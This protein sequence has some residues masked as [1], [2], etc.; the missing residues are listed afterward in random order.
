MS[1]SVL[2]LFRFVQAVQTSATFDLISPTLCWLVIIIILRKYGIYEIS[3][4]IELHSGPTTI[5][6]SVVK[7]VNGQAVVG[8]GKVAA[9]TGRCLTDTFSVSNQNTLPVICGTNTGE[10]GKSRIQIQITQF[11]PYCYIPLFSLLWCQLGVQLAWFQ[12]GNCCC[13]CHCFSNKNVDY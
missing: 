2:P 10:H 12:H 6:T 9:E 11:E 1:L 4:K 3:I 5:S 8:A 7:L 13:W